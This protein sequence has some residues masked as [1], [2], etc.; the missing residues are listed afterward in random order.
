MLDFLF[1]SKCVV[2]AKPTKPICTDCLLK[3]SL[4]P[5]K[6]LRDIPV[7]YLSEYGEEIGKVLTYIKDKGVTALIPQLIG[8]RNLLTDFSEVLLVPIPSSPANLKKRGFSHTLLMAKKLARGQ[9]GS[10]V[11]DVLVSSKRRADQ[12]QLGP[13]ERRA[14]LAGAFRVKPWAM[15]G[16]PVL[17]VDDVHTTGATAHEAARVLSQAGYSVLGCWVVALVKG[18]KPS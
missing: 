9:T 8:K 1:P 13:E 4:Q 2:C 5:R 7:F 12:T 17:L 14:N 18:P 3:L 10:R 6:E 15:P 11:W 16:Q